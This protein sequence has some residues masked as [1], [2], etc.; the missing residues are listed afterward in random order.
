MKGIERWKMYGID[1]F[2]PIVGNTVHV[3]LKLTNSQVTP[4]IV[5]KLISEM[6]GF[7]LNTPD[8]QYLYPT[9]KKVHV[10]QLPVFKTLEEVN[11]YSLDNLIPNVT[12]CLGRIAVNED[13]IS[14]GMNHA[15]GD[16]G[17]YKGVFDHIA[18]PKKELESLFPVSPIDTYRD[19]I[20]QYKHITPEFINNDENLTSI[21]TVAPKKGV[22]HVDIDRYPINTLACYN[23][24]KQTCSFL[25]EATCSSYLF[26]GII[27]DNKTKLPEEIVKLPFGIQILTDLRKKLKGRYPVSLCSFNWLSSYNIHAKPQLNM[28]M[29]DVYKQ[30]RQDLQDKASDHR[31]WDFVRALD[32]EDPTPAHKWDN[33]VFMNNSNLG[34]I[35]IKDPIKDLILSCVTHTIPSTIM[36]SLM[37]YTLKDKHGRNELV[38]TLRYGSNGINEKHAKLLNS[39]TKY[40]LQN[41][42]QNMTVREAI[43]VIKDYMTSN[44][45]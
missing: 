9:N 33:L 5:D 30:M 29:I 41:V 25:N 42:H 4:M 38:Q 8:N 31:L 34:Q 10:E 28:K 36:S 43:K 11:Q 40:A 17:Y 1:S 2:S 6:A 19:H 18:D 22:E 45:Q 24:E 21:H 13:T 39:V 16:G 27:A 15:C 12:E 14:I 20:N 23:K 26:A 35:E 44:F 32:Y 37:T 3:T 7:H